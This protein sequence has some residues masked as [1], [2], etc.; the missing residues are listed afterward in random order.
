[1]TIPAGSKLGPYEVLS[2]LGAG[3]MGE[4]YRA[5]DSRLAREV[6]IKVL[7]ASFSN[8]PDRLRRFEQEAKAAGLLNHPN[9]TA[10]YDIGTHEG[11]PYVVQ[12]LLE[13]ET[14]RSMIIGGRLSP[15]KVLDYSVQIAH[16][17]AEAHE[18][19]IVH[20]DLKPEN[21]FVTCDGRVKILDFGLA[22]LTQFGQGNEGSDLST[23]TAMTEPGVAVGTPSYMSPE[24]VRGEGV[25]H[26]SDIFSFGTILYEMLSGERPFCGATSVETMN[27]ILKEDPAELVVKAVSASV[28]LRRIVLHCLE[29]SP[30]ERFQ[31]ARDLAFDLKGLPG[32]TSEAPAAAAE[33]SAAGPGRPVYR[34]VTFR[35][36]TIGRARFSPD[37]QTIVCSARWEGNPRETYLMRFDS[38]E[39]RPLGLPGA[40]LHAISSS[41]EMAFVLCGQRNPQGLGLRGVLV[42]MPLAGG[43]PREILE[44]VLYADWSP[45]GKDLA[46]VR[47]VGGRDRL[48]FPIGTALYEPTGWVAFPRVSPRGDLI[49]FLDY[50]LLGDTAGAVAIVDRK[51]HVKRL[52]HVWPDTLGLAWSPDG[53]EI[54]FTASDLGAAR[55]LRAVTLEGR[56]RRLE[57]VPGGL[58]LH[59]IS[60]SGKVLLSHHAKRAGILCRINNE[61]T[62]RELS[63]L[64]YSNSPDLSSDGRTLLF[65]EEGEGGGPLCSVYL[66]KTDGSP[67]IRLGE[68]CP[69]ALSPDGKVALSLPASPGKL[70]LLPTGA[71][72]VRELPH[73]GL[74]HHSHAAWFADGKRILFA[75]NEEGTPPRS[76]V[77]DVE[78]AEFRPVTPVG[79]IAYAVSPDARYVAAE[80]PAMLYPVE[81]GE[82]IPIRGALP[83]DK[84]IRWHQDGRSLFIRSGF[85]PTRVFLVDQETGS[86]KLFLEL[87]PS[88]PVGMGSFLGR[89]SITPDGCSYAY[90]HYGDLSDLYVVEGLK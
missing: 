21:I 24:Q 5:R 36:G 8:D 63:W 74:T 64:D 89:I 25:D 20:R 42:R 18:K 81:G 85:S 86:R 47:V 53:E 30:R 11:A 40:M 19:G 16:G 82:P 41:G 73:E 68:G 1:M 84:P 39:S 83:D 13:G 15:R 62:E 76:Y 31:S 33:H 10:V 52:S 88:D 61:A 57:R 29:K 45:D 4:V 7:P 35:R 49:A 69:L 26:R 37:A 78:R 6:A 14:L 43:S 51:R 55:A 77:Q 70:L 72:Q 28:G 3:G 48:D 90:A 56:E 2:P 75:A 58:Y 65:G 44:D 54:W 80:E 66:R 46:V 79:A 23:V 87:M 67:A 71:G 12:E 9:I 34:R 32:V 38:A 59:D 27:A 50:A 60:P 22:K 17:L